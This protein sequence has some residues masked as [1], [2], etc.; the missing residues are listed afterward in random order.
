MLFRWYA[1]DF[2]TDSKLSEEHVSQERRANP[3]MAF[4]TSA[5]Y[6]DQERRRLP[7][8]KFRRLHLNLPG[9]PDGTYLDAE[10]VLSAIVEGRRQLAALPDVSYRA[11]VDMS[12]GSSDDA[13]LG[14]SHFDSINNR[15]V[16]DALIAQTGQPPFNPRSAVAKFA[17]LLKEYRI[18]RVVG[19]RFAGETFRA[20]FQEREISYEVS[21]LT[22]HE[23]Y[24]AFEP[25][26]NAGDVELLDVPKLQEQ[27]LGLVMRG[28]KIDHMLGEHD[29]YAN[30]AAGAIWLS[31]PRIDMG[32]ALA[33]AEAANASAGLN[34]SLD[35]RL[36]EMEWR[37][38]TSGLDDA[39]WDR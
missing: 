7:T 38:T 10:R 2:T 28:Q 35:T 26:L 19:D 29:D 9:M 31:K 34:Q 36:A 24:E 14:I 20:D 17:A 18:S 12:G 1:A 39:P 13:T 5:D 6:L 22:K 37:S 21:P 4:W 33:D 8:H 15:A 3:A 25:R 32:Q 16:L 30:S 27:L 23:L 11:F